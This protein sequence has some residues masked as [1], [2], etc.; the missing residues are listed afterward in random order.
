M[1]AEALR[2]V[3]QAAPDADWRE[4]RRAAMRYVGQG[5]EIAVP[6]ESGVL[7]PDAAE[8][9]GR[10]FDAEYV[11][12]YGRLIPGLDVE[13]LSWTLGLAAAGDT[14]TGASPSGDAATGTANRTDKKRNAT[15]GRLF[16][17]ATGETVPVPL[18]HRAS[19]T[20]GAVLA[21]PVLI[22]EEQTTAVVPRAFTARVLPAGHLLIERVAE[23][24]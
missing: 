18:V 21:G 8:T 7:G 6:V 23:E 22:A 19:L 20:A 13:V 1:R 3:G 5:Y 11:R 10:A 14:N 15:D 24:A 9:L 4:T 12:L 2:V 16:D 17:P